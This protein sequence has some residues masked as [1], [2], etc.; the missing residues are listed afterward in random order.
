MLEIMNYMSRQSTLAAPERSSQ[1]ELFVIKSIKAFNK[2]VRF[3]N[4]GSPFLNTKRK[5]SISA[6]TGHLGKSFQ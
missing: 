6:N 4:T 3:L 2:T 5:K 1:D